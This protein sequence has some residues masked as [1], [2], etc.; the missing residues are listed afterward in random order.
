MRFKIYFTLLL[1]LAFSVNIFAKKVDRS[2]AERVA[3]HFYYAQSNLFDEPLSLS[4]IDIAD[5]YKVGQAYFVF[6]MEEGWVIVAADDAMWPVI[7]YSFQG[8]FPAVEDMDYNLQSWMTTFVDEAA[9]VEA[10]NIQ[11]NTTIAAEWAK[12]DKPDEEFVMPGG[13]RSEVDPLLISLWNQD[14]PYNILCPEDDAGPGGHV[15]VGCVATAMSQIMYYWRYPN[16]GQGSFAYY[17]YPY[18]TISADFG[19]T[20]Y[21]WDGMQNSIDSENPWEIALIGFH[22]GVSVQM[23]YSP[24]GSGAYGSKVPN[25]LKNYFTYDNSAQYL[26]KKNFSTTQWESMLQADLDNS[27]PLY[28]EGYSS[29]GGHAFVC[30]GYQGTNYYHFNFG[31][32][33][34]GNGY[35][36]L[37]DVGG[38]YNDQGIVRYIY[39]GDDDFPYIAEGADTLVEPSGSFTDGSSIEDYPAGMSASWLI[40]PQTEDDS[41][42]SIRLSFAKF[43]TAT[44]DT[45]YVYAGNS[46]QG[47]LLGKFAGDNLPSEIDYDGNQMYITFASTGTG[48][49]FYA[50]YNT[51][52]PSWCSSSQTYTDPSGSFSDGSGSFLYNNNTTCMYKITN[53]EAVNITLEFT[54]FATEED[55]DMVQ[56]YDGKTQEL[57]GQ[58]SGHDLPDVLD[59]QTSSL[60]ILWAT[61]S[62]VKDEGWTA[63]YTIDGVGIKEEMFTGFE[64]Y[65]NPSSGALNIN[66]DE[67]P[68][69]D[70]YLQIVSMNGQLVY[71]EKLESRAQNMS[72]TIDLNKEPKGVYLISL[73]TSEN[74]IDRKIVLK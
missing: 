46:G 34:S 20:T 40:S 13:S 2:T 49:G 59:V 26:K 53:P 11:A 6:N 41:I 4:D 29:S 74:K 42:S 62:T 39:P 3:V 66:I 14:F 61:N 43:N 72:R 17:Q 32:S 24:S 10:N 7:G 5:E 57:L 63:E 45:L 1:A 58:Y 54:E 16:Q 33:G 56:I 51:T 73:I 69:G 8:N 44:T 28:Y 36:T 23:N 60:I 64:V 12:Y 48:E 37:Q 52:N 22:A 9:F 47:E 27:L 68:A 55:Y 30:D 19:N 18:G 71:K 67:L 21:L 38:F 15:Y 35:Y 25:A 50:E 65:P 31:W 70:A